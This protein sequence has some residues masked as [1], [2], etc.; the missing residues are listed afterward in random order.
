MDS[1]TISSNI[2]QLDLYQ[3]TLSERK[4][5]EIQLLG[6]HLTSLGLAYCI[7]TRDDVICTLTSFSPN[8]KH[9]NIEGVSVNKSSGGITDAGTLAIVQNLKELQSL[10]IKNNDHLTDASLVHIYSHCAKRLHTLHLNC[11]TEE[12]LRYVYSPSTVNALLERCTSLTNMYF[13]YW[14]VDDHWQELDVGI[15]FPPITTQNL[16][17]LVIGG[18]VV[19]D[20]NLHAIS[21]Y[22]EN[23]QTLAIFEANSC[24]HTSLMNLLEGCPK[25]TQFY[26]DKSTMK[27][28]IHDSMLIAAKARPGLVVQAAFPQHLEQFEVIDA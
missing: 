2:T 5:L 11:S 8:I 12:G 6:P 25:L 16:R 24:T 28:Q 13:D 14:H 3:L 19:S 22:G 15:V 18:N 9:L 20:R 27:N 17:K 10:N 26:A 7:F 21:T 1:L 4:L 23:L